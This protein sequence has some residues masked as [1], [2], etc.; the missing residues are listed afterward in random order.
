[1]NKQKLL[2]QHYKKAAWPTILFFTFMLLAAAFPVQ[3]A[4][5]TNNE[6]DKPQFVTKAAESAN[7]A[8][9]KRKS[10]FPWLVAGLGGI[11]VGLI[12]YVMIT[13]KTNYEF[14]PLEFPFA[15]WKQVIRM[16][17]FGIPNWSGTKPHNGIDLQVGT[18]VV[19]VSPT[20]GTVDDIKVSENPYSNPVG[21]LILSVKI[22]INSQRSVSLVFEPST[23]AAGTKAQQIA[24]II[25]KKGDKV[26][27]GTAVGT[28]L[29]GE[30]GYPH[31]H[32]MLWD[33]TQND[34]CPY[35][36]SSAA[37]MTIFEKLRATLTNNSLP[38]G[39]ICYGQ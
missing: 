19:I 11:A 21:Q 33:S 39:K 23:T 14:A 7:D 16:A 4:V 6:N 32:F 34:L 12:L 35:A 27:V 1:M 28:L 9:E 37:S 38:D 13:Q 2:N 8:A 25:V 29:V 22:Y 26:A 24:A 18:Q 36:Y 30:R 17:A 20:A 10:H 3:G 5:K 31:L 15:N